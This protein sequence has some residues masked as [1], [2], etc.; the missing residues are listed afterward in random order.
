[1]LAE[2]SFISN[3]EDEKLLREAGYIGE[4]SKGIAQGVTDYLKDIP[5]QHVAKK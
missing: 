5:A 1:V 2:V 3:L 4:V